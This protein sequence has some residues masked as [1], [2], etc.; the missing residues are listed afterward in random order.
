MIPTTQSNKMLIDDVTQ[1]SVPTQ[2]ADENGRSRSDK[3]VIT[4][5]EAFHLFR[6]LDHKRRRRVGPSRPPTKTNRMP[7]MKTSPLCP[8]VERSNPDILSWP[9]GVGREVEPKTG[10]VSSGETG[11]TDRQKKRCCGRTDEEAEG[12][13]KDTG[14]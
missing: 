3:A 4:K 10:T 6:R 11:L 2:G 14:M 1:R 5:R 8:S 7:R 12:K 9:N 13:E